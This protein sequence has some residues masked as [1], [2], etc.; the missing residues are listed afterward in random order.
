MLELKRIIA[1]VITTK[2]EEAIS[3]YRDK[4]GFTLVGNDEFAL[5]FD[6]NGTMIRV[7]KLKPEQFRAAPHT[8]L[9]WRVADAS[10][11]AAEL[12]QRGISF[13]RYPGMG[14]DQEGIWTS[15][16]GAKVA[17][18]K[19]PEGNVLSISQFPQ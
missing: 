17:W 15:P 10:R 19:D 9:G 12:K 3:F 14:Q 5:V 4:L 11:A 13:E 8:V 6:A 18:F 16:S 1:F 2:P 7:V